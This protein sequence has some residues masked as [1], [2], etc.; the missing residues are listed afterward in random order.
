MDC[1]EFSNLLDAYVDGSLS[2]AEADQMRD[3]AAACPD[4]AA[5]LIL[6]KDARRM[7]EEIEVP[8]AFSS[9]WRQMIREEETMEE[10]KKGR[11][12]P[13]KSWLAAAAVLVFVL[14]GTALTRGGMPSRSKVTGSASA[15]QARSSNANSV[16]GRNTDTGA[17]AYYEYSQAAEAPMLAA[18]YDDDYDVPEMEEAAEEA[19]A[20]KGSEARQEK[21]IRNASFT[22]KT[23]DYDSDL[24]RLQA[25]A[26]DMGGRVEYLNTFG[27]ASTGQTRSASLTLRIPSQRLD[28]FLAGAEGIGNVTSMTQEM[29]DV[30]DS[31]Y[32][33]KTRLETQ[34]KKLARLQSMF[35]VA[36][37]VSDLIEIESA[38]ADAQYYIDRYTSQIK[39]YDA[40]VD[41]STVRVSV[42]EVRVTE[43]KEV[44][45]GQRI[46]EGF[47]DS[48]QATMEFLEDTV[49]FL[50]SALPW[51]I[52]AGAVALVI[53]LIV[54]KTKKNNKRREGNQ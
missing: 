42:K 3:H 13:W 54:R 12:F 35:E 48:L 45:L 50:V 40:K 51:L 20:A 4:C 16:T 25:L 29:Q 21:I 44:T 5:R 49:I 8:E 7:D 15:S 46:S 11:K 22:V 1:K 47:Q 30:S 33:V 9:S 53:R 38:I 34:Q 41:Y 28:E 32:D 19:A 18:A 6:L 26:K 2:K 23:T 17:G 14:G 43:M 39:S 24:E 37:E 52:A 10:E 31:Y 27:D 36:D